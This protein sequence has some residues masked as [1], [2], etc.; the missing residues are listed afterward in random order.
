[1]N[2]LKVWSAVLDDS[3]NGYCPIGVFMTAK[4]ASDAC[5][6][7]H[8][9]VNGGEGEPKL[10]LIWKK[11]EHWAVECFESEVDEWHFYVHESIIGE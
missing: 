8:N 11:A 5:L 9:E 1:M 6:A 10:L 4:D 2:G 7:Y 3:E